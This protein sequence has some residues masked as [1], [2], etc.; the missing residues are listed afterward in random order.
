MSVASP[1][2]SVMRLV[3]QAVRTHRLIEAGDRV[4]CGISGGKDSLLLMQC[5]RALQVRSDYD[6]ELVPVHLDQHQPGF[7]RENFDRAMSELGIA[8]EVVSKDTWSVVQSKLPPGQIPCALCSRMRRGVLVDWCVSRGINRLALG[9]HLDDAIETFFLNL[10]FQRR[11][12]PLKPLTPT[13]HGV[14]VIRP[15]LLV[16]EAQ[17]VAW[18]D[19]HKLE[20]IPCPVCDSIPT[21]KRRSVG[22]LLETMRSEHPELTQSVRHALYGS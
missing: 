19:T 2:K 17:V 11:L 15:L 20:P 5:L 22:Q 4:A 1:S 10:F 9:H 7:Q 8:V 13:D 6:F 12:D 18:R 21:S 3:D 14:S 16:E